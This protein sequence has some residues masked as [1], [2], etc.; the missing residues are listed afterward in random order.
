MERKG[1]QMKKQ[2]SPRIYHSAFCSAFL[3]A[4]VVLLGS[5]ASLAQTAPPTPPSGLT[6]STPTCGE[7]DLS[8][9]PAVDNSGTGLRAYTVTRNDNV[10][11]SI[12]AARTTFSDTNYVKSST[13]IT[14]YIT[15]LDNAGNTSSPSNSVSVTS[16]P[17]PQSAGEQI[18]DKA[19][20]EPFGK[21]MGTYGT[22]TAL[23]Y[24]KQ[25]TSLTLDTW[26]YLHDSNTGQNSTFLLH[27]APSYHQVESDYVLTSATDLWALSYDT[28]S[29]GKLLVSHY[30]LNGT[31]ASSATLVSTQPLG[32]S[33]SNA[34][35]MIRLRSGALFVAWN[36]EG[37]GYTLPD[38]SVNNGYA[39]L[40][41]NGKWSVQFPVNIPNP[42]ANNTTMSQ[43]ILAQHPAD[44][45]IWSFVKR[46][47]FTNLN[48]LH[49]SETLTGFQLDWI[50]TG[51]ITP[52]TDGV[53][54]P[55]GEFPFLAATGDSTRNAILLAYQ[56]NQYQMVFID[57][58][59]NSM[60]SIFLKQAYATVAQV[61]A[62]GSK[63]FIPFPNYMERGEQFGFSVLSDGTLWL[64]Y[65]PINS[66]T[67]TW[68]EVYASEYTNNA[69]STP[70]LA[71]FNYTNYDVESAQRDPGFIVSRKDAPVAAFLTPDQNVH[72][73]DLSNLAPA[74]SDTT[75]PT[76][77]ITS[78]ANG[79][80]LSGSV[81]I[82]A[83]ASDNVGVTR[84]EL[85]LDGVLGATATT[86]PYNFTWNTAASTNGSHT[87]QTKA[88]D[89]AGNMGVSSI[90]TVTA[91]NLTATSLAVSITNPTNG[92]T[93]PRN[94]YVMI[95]ASATD[96][97]TITRVQFYV[98]NNLLGTVSTAP[99]SYPWRVPGKK[100]SHSVK[101]QA[102]DAKGNSAVQAITVTAQ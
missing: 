73:V 44:G 64:A 24:A 4:V 45:S 61:G 89:A 88:Y 79:S 75:P 55:Q 60:N 41:P 9:S 83:S 47:S 52:T 59:L 22:L 93:V 32:D 6:A 8:W 57:P 49:F 18:I 5:I 29:G 51:F 56:T 92:G 70:A 84:V 20:I 76:T 95:N 62:D 74:P 50:N 53:N 65:Q 100:G 77:S 34:K 90:M 16:P 7:V 40:S 81:T 66:Q 46:D 94:T 25:N 10:N 98:D 99:Y 97:T 2:I 26:L 101:A 30:T 78:P 71:G 86:A 63:A 23:I 13:A 27:K 48:A 82:S 39:Y 80:T 28:Y 72:T 17:C 87:L 11:T 68:N 43:I 12:G 33:L 19:Y 58:L 15:A 67:L 35:S 1:G 31:P 102:Y 14:Y 69:W 42:Y 96:N 91:S 85:W 38:G 36:E 54:S 3:L 37:W 21:N